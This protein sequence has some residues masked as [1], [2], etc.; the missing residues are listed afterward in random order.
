MSKS[1]TSQGKRY[2]EKERARILAFVD[3]T[4]AMKGRGGIAAAAR[5][6]GVTPLTISHWLKKVG[7]SP[8][9]RHASGDFSQNLRRLAE[10]HEAIA[11]KEADLVRLR[12]EYTTLKRKL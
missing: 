3:K 1:R 9:K 10:L 6:F 7:A 8:A 12:R 5:K 11:A 2:T 4:N